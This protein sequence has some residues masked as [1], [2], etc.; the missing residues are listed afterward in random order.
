MLL[1][2]RAVWSA[3]VRL[4][5]QVYEPSPESLPRLDELTEYVRANVRRET[6]GRQTPTSDRGSFD[7][8]I[9]TTGT[10]EYRYTPQRP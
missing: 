3:A 6:Q 10:S 4:G 1:L 5:L 8:K 9:V 2:R 7:G